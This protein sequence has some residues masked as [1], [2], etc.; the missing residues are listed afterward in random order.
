ME[1]SEVS[2]LLDECLV[3]MIGERG[4]VAALNQP[5]N[6]CPFAKLNVS[7]TSLYFM[8]RLGLHCQSYHE[9]T[10]WNGKGEWISRYYHSRKV[11]STKTL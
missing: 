2:R 11:A 8:N 1:A 6:L 4:M 3:V 5:T 9:R 10:H 7:L